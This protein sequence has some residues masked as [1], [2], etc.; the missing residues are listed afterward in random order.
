MKSSTRIKRRQLL[1]MALLGGAYGLLPGKLFTAC[2]LLDSTVEEGE[3]NFDL[4]NK[5]VVV[6]GAG[7]SGLSAAQKL[8]E[9]GAE[10][11]VLEAQSRLGGRLWTDRSLGSPFEMGAG[12]IHGPRGNPLTELVDSIPATTFVTDDDSLVVYD[13]S[14]KQITET[15]VDQLDADFTTLIDQVDE[16]MDT[17][18]D[19]S[20]ESAIR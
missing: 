10:V 15:L 16:F 14:G 11:S 12:W 18:T 5:K 2:G 6:V 19:L 3:E 1:K 17:Q 8:K 4:A 13:K 7:V 9:L 20:L